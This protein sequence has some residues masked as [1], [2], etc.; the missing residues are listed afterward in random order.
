MMTRREFKRALKR[1]AELNRE[2]AALTADR[3]WLARKVEAAEILL[4]HAPA[5]RD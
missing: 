2:I 5:N 1:L 4:V 3:D